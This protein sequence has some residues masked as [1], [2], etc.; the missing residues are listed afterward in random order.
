MENLWLHSAKVEFM[1]SQISVEVYSRIGSAEINTLSIN[2]YF[3]HI[4]WQ[5][6]SMAQI[7]NSLGQ[8]F[9]SGEHLT[10]GQ[11]EHS[12]STKE[13]SGFDRTEWRNI[14]RSSYDVR[15]LC[16]ANGLVEELSRCL[17]LES[18]EIPL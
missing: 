4:D 10:L 11:E 6:S 8:M 1:G 2:F 18:G 13:H 16:I 14:L 7:F 9:S 15:P 17:R 12:L 5:V 3:P